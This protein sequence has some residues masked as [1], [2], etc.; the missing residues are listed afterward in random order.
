M[1]QGL[2]EYAPLEQRIQASKPPDLHS[3]DAED[4]KISR[5]SDRSRVGKQRMGRR[6]VQKMRFR[7]LGEERPCSKSEGTA[8][9]VNIGEGQPLSKG[10]SD[11]RFDARCVC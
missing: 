8:G 2:I 10:G 1:P 5:I 4:I 3:I 9:G 7:S 11:H 6:Y